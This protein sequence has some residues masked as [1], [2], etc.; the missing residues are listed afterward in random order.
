[1]LI[2]SP[3]EFSKIATAVGSNANLNRIGLGLGLERFIAGSCAGKTV[4]DTVEAILGAIYLDSD[5]EKV[6]NVMDALDLI[7]KDAR[8]ERELEMEGLIMLDPDDADGAQNRRRK[9]LRSDT[10]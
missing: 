6:K 10:L 5:I 3:G 7:P 4:A 8:K 2:R 1:M 9:R